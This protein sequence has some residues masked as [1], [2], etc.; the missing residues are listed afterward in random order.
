VTGLINA[1]LIA[2]V[3][4]ALGPMHYGYFTYLQQFF[5]QIV[6]FLDAG[7]SIGFFTKLSADNNRK[8]LLKFYLFFSLLLLLFLFILIYFC[9]Y[10]GLLN[11]VFSGVPG[12]YIYVGLWFGY[13]TW[14]TQVYIKISDAY[15]L[16]VSVELIKIAHKILMLGALLYIVNY[17][18]FDLSVYFYFHL[19][20][21]ASFVV[22]LSFLFLDR[23]I[24][25]Y[26]ILSMKFS[27]RTL[28]SEFYKFC[29]PLFIFNCIA[30]GVG[31]FDI[32]LL[33]KISGS[34][35]MGFYGLA[36]SI[37][38]MCFL[39]TSAM[40]PVITREF[41]KSYQEKE[42]SEMKRLFNRYV[43]M[44]YAIATYFSV[45]IAFQADNLLSIFTDERFEGA[46]L[47]LVIIAYYPLHQT[48]G[49][50][51]AALFFAT[52]DTRKYRNIGLVT[53]VI[54]LIFSYIFIYTLKWGAEGL[55]WKM[56]VAQIIGVN[57]QL[58]FNAKKLDIIYFKF[59]YHQFYTIIF[60]CV[61]A[62]VANLL[63]GAYTAAD[64]QFFIT[65]A[66]YSCLALLGVFMFPPIFGV[67]REELTRF[68]RNV[69][70]RIKN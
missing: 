2:V 47:A 51:N 46:Y 63:V 4:K 59:L 20:S 45:F 66:V 8:E 28:M 61:V 41:S 26:S 25:R 29:S 67:S 48:Y 57:I 60:F 17:L 70:L 40:T 16:T 1:L 49:Q 22:L 7:T 11:Y 13:L 68:F 62:F 39:F 14:F 10:L 58:F 12:R 38:A 9:E 56:V 64:I 65:G 55:A 6:A 37:A 19:L 24:F 50:I 3:P 54:G 52:E 69:E 23:G 34:I 44:L 33:Q 18:S 31:L 27:I 43:P 21:L 30:V 15:A 35:E 53:T 42:F 32:W 36:F 5:S